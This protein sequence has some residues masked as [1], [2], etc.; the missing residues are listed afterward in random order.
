MP[1]RLVHLLARIKAMEAR[2]PADDRAAGRAQASRRLSLGQALG[3]G[4]SK[5]GAPS[6]QGQRPEC[7]ERKLAA[8]AASPS[9]FAI[10][11]QDTK[12]IHL[13]SPLFV[14]ERLVVVGQ[15]FSVILSCPD[16]SGSAIIV[17]T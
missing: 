6:L 7:I 1:V 14:A 13:E 17:L 15:Q 12:E 3:P 16:E 4:A 5:L 2:V 10:N 9:E 8:F 11:R